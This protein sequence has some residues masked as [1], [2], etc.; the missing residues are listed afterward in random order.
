MA[1]LE[2]TP[3]PSGLH[4]RSLVQGVA[5]T[6][7]V[8]ALGAAA[9]AFAVSCDKLP[10]LAMQGDWSAATTTGGLK[11]ATGTYANGY[12]T[13]SGTG[14]AV[15]TGDG[16]TRY[17]SWQDDS[18]TS[19]GLSTVTITYA[20][21]GL[22]VGQRYTL[23]YTTQMGPGGVGATGGVRRSQYVDVTV[24]AGGV[25]AGSD[26]FGTDAPFSP[27]PAGYEILAATTAYPVYKRS[28][29][30]TA[31]ATTMT[32]T[33]KFTLPATTVSTDAN[34]DIGVGGFTIACAP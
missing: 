1:L 26:K 25:T 33:V 28:I 32:L 31:S 13:Y 20:I 12:K 7:P 27:P 15:G 24:S 16:V 34:D 19:I 9:P 18:P 8:L 3:Q 23:N 30:F 2:Q 5:W 17:W 14:T 21:S 6:V 29:T 4:R 22:N 10:S 11:P